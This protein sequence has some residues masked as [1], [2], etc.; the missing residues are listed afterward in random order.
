MKRVPFDAIFV[1]IVGVGWGL[2]APAT[3]AMF[4]ADPAAFDG[5]TVAVARAA[6]ALPA[7]VI[8]LAATLA[9]ERPRLD[10]RRWVAVVAAGVCFGLG[11]STVFSI[12]AQHTS[13]AHI[14]FLIGTSPVTNS[15]VAALVFRLPIGRRQ[16]I[17]LVLGIAG[18]ALLASAQTGGRSG[19]VGDGLML[20]WLA[21]F[22]VYA[23]LLRYVGPRVSSAFTMSAVGVIAMGSVVVLAAVAAPEELRGVPHVLA[24][25]AAGWWFFGEIVLGSN[26]IAQTAYARAVRRLGVSV[27]TIG[28]QYTAL[29]V[30]ITASILSHEAW[31]IVTAIAG[32]IL[33]GALAVTFVPLPARWVRAPQPS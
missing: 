22:A 8:M 25:P 33:C 21:A 13:V 5:T 7:F 14:S 3:K 20:V 31:T 27:A 24:T 1:V 28:A 30:G 15:L 32:L 26:V 17:A 2:L 9:F 23:V 16:R 29:A 6:W 19:I 18:V 10:A 4:A 11:I 12:A